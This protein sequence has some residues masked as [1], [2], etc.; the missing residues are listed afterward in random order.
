MLPWLLILAGACVFGA[1][2]SYGKIY[3]RRR[4]FG[5]PAIPEDSR[6]ASQFVAILLPRITAQ[7]HRYAMSASELGEFLG[8]LKAAGYTSI[9]VDDVEQLYLRQRR[10]PPKALMIAFAQD[11]PQSISAADGVMKSLRL[12]GVAFIRRISTSGIE[13]QRR[14]INRHAVSQMRRAGAWDFGWVGQDGTRNLLPAGEIRALLNVE[15][16]RS[17]PLDPA[18]FTLRFTAAELGLNDGSD[19]PRALN[20]LSIRPDRPAGE[21]IRIVEN[22]WPR[23]SEFVEDFSAEGLGS[24]WVVGWGVVSMGS[25]RLAILPTPRQSGAGVFLRGTEK[26]RDQT[27]AFELKRYQKEFWLY[28]R[29]R[30]DGRFIRVG[31]RNGYWYVEQ[32]IGDRYLPSM[33]ARAPILDGALPA[34]VRLVL[35]GGFAIVYVNGRM[36]FGRAL[37]INPAV[38]RGRVLLGVYDGRSRS[39]LAVVTSVRAAPLG[40]TWISSKVGASGGFDENDLDGLREEAALARAVSPSWVKVAADGSV[41]VAETQGVLIRSLAGFYGCRLVPMADITGLAASVLESPVRAQKLATDLSEAA[42]N[43]DAPGLN[44]RLNRTSVGRRETIAFLTRLHAAFHVG[45]RELWVTID[46]SGTASA[47]I[48]GVDGVLEPSRAVKHDFELLEA[49]RRPPGGSMKPQL[50]LAAQPA[51]AEAQRRPGAMGAPLIQ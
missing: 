4:F 51:G 5:V 19:D 39:A 17:R 2:V 20:V 12:R 41:S 33:L 32:K 47:S 6:I 3:V 7:K 14:F 1:W 34:Q 15:E 8:G 31:A 22:S 27:L 23:A 45:R 21:N 40:E 44:L 18:P 49:A 38:D 16:G 11:D 10:L 43:L 35:K 46:G 24:D 50:P 36:Q 26:W 37:R 30:D 25:H 9:G 13:E 48:R 29:Y 28:A 42:R